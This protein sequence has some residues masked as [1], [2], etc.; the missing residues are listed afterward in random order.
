MVERIEEF[1]ERLDPY[2]VMGSL[3]ESL[4]VLR[5]PFRLVG[6]TSVV[7]ESDLIFVWHPS[8]RV[9]FD[10]F[11]NQRLMDFEAEWEIV[12]DGSPGF[13][14][15]S[16]LARQRPGQSGDRV[17]GFISDR[18]DIG[19]GPMETVRFC[20]A[21]FPAYLGTFVRSEQSVFMGRLDMESEIGTVTVDFLPEVQE[22][23]KS[24]R[25]QPG[26][27]VSHVGHWIPSAA[28]VSVAEAEAVLEMLRVWFG[29]LR[30]AWAGPLFPGGL[31]QRF[32]V[33]RQFASWRLSESRPVPSWLP[34]R[35][36]LDLHGAFAGFS[37]LWANPK[38][39][40]PLKL[41]VSWLAE[42]NSSRSS[43]ETK[44]VL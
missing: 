39:R 27:V 37:G 12:K 22:L 17:N 23:L 1:P 28:E 34:T 32:V 30:G 13:R 20:L 36:S 40:R 42:A 11:T 8:M 41:A 43:P 10:G 38:W 21:N 44:I 26:F 5:G 18:L 19:E 15:R 31:R 35:H 3:D 33:W 9:A 14:V 29:F 7:L 4:P 24:T 2:I 6:P 25:T 16:L